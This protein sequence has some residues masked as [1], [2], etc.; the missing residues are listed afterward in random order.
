MPSVRKDL[1]EL[2]YTVGGNVK[3]RAP[4]RSI[5]KFFKKLNIL[6]CDLCTLLLDIY[7]IEMKAYV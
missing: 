2:K 4:W 5:Y 3:C 6:P 7:H 1:E